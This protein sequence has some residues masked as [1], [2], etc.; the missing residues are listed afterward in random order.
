MDVRSLHRSRV[1]AQFERLI[2]RTLAR[3][4]VSQQH[5]FY[6]DYAQELRLKLLDIEVGFDGKALGADRIR[7]VGFAG[8]GLYWHLI[9]LLR[10]EKSVLPSENVA[11]LLDYGTGKLV[12]T[13]PGEAASTGML[14][15]IEEARRLLS[16]D[17][18]ELFL[19]LCDGTWSMVEL[20]EY[21]GVGRQTMYKRK[22]RLAGKLEKLKGLLLS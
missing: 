9:S 7:F 12:C 11:E 1:L 18:F 2:H 6:E 16:G 5:M 20:A 3:A 14:V 19:L 13:A 22:E 10:K 17:E 21:Y 15:F 8:R 4:Q